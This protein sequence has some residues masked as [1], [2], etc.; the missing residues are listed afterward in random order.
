MSLSE[1]LPLPSDTPNV[2]LVTDS[3]AVVEW[4]QIVGISDELAPFY[5][6]DIEYKV[7]AT[8]NWITWQGNFTHSNNAVGRFLEDKLTGLSDNTVYTVRI[9]SYRVLRG[10]TNETG[11]T[12]E[13]VFMTLI[14]R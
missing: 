4:K 5:R 14:K 10:D 8:N 3:T 12:R 11:N 9:K 2:T 1:A 7:D 13:A 6:Y